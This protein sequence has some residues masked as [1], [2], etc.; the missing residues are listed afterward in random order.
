MKAIVVYKSKT[1]FTKRYA[2][3]IVEELQCDITTYENIFREMIAEYDLVIYGSRIHAGRVDGL[4]KIKD[5]VE[6]VN[7]PKL[8]VFATGGTPSAVEGAIR[9][10]WKASFSEEELQ[11]IPH[12]YM[13]SGLNYEKMG[14]G[15]R[16]I[17]K[18]LAKVLN[19]KKDKTSDEVGCEEAIGDSYDISSREYVLPLVQCVQEMK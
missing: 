9:G 19:R 12:F 6:K 17:M 1:G 10:I 14:R 8:M 2:E 13:Q 16:L 3:W 7:R 18:T 5:L 11:E 4:K 15:D